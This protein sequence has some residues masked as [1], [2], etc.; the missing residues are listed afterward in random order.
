MFILRIKKI[1]RQYQM[2]KKFRDTVFHEYALVNKSSKLAAYTVLFR[3]VQ[4]ID[5]CIGGYTYIQ[6]NSKV[7]NATIG[8]FCSIASN[9][10]IGLAS[11]P[12]NRV[13]THPVFYDN[14]QP[15]PSFFTDKNKYENNLPRTNIGADVWIGQGAMIK[16]GVDIG[17]GVVIGAGA[18]VTKNVEPYSIVAGVPAK[19]IRMRFEKRICEK[20]FTSQWWM[21]GDSKLEKLSPYF[22]NPEEMLKMLGE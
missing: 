6:E 20:L 13:S 7:Y 21:L 19:V 22:N 9:V 18:V 17:V 1:I 3:N 11:H 4:L 10:T 14:T 8:S 15:L 12:T 16:A 2:K 5:V